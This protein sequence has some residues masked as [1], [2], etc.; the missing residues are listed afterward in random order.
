MVRSDYRV[1]WG[2]VVLE[3][4][5]NDTLDTGVYIGG[6]ELGKYGARRVN[7]ETIYNGINGRLWRARL[8]F[9]SS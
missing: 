8:S 7:S 3:N 4:E 1:Y 6:Y 5:L 2:D 9:Y